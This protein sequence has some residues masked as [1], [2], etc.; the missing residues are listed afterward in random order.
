M[1]TCVQVTTLVVAEHKGDKLGADA[2]S[3]INAAKCLGGDISILLA[4]EGVLPIAQHASTVPGVGK[5]T[6]LTLRPKC[7][8]PSSFKV[9]ERS[10]IELMCRSLPPMM[11]C[12]ERAQPRALQHC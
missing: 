8:S 4:G 11:R 12:L 9:D 10:T 7:S 2:L 6:A 3:A 5:V 1:L